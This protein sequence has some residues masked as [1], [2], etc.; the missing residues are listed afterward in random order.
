MKELKCTY[1]GNDVE[2]YIKEQYRGSCRFYFRTDG[3]EADNSQ[4]YDGAIHKQG[5]YVYCANCHK[6]IKVV[7]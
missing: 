5:K 6:T 7:E 3:V 2:F 4:I 1:C